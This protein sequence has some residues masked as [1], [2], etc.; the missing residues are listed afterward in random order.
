[1]SEILI[2]KDESPPCDK[3]ILLKLWISVKDKLPENNTRVL[4]WYAGCAHILMWYADNHF[5][6]VL[7]DC[8]SSKKH[9]TK[10]VSHWMLLPQE[11]KKE[12]INNE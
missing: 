8:Y 6:E 11:P 2:G 7:V 12:E 1:M 5:D 4:A 3:D 10:S 9:Q